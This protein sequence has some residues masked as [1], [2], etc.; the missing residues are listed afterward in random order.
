VFDAIGA[1]VEPSQF[2]GHFAISYDA[3]SRVSYQLNLANIIN[4]CFGG[5]QKPW[6]SGDHRWCNYG[7]IG[8]N[9]PSV[10]N[11]YNP[12][13]TLQ[14]LVKYPYVPSGTTGANAAVAPFNASFNVTFKL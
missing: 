2:S 12:G 9:L 8:G 1:F 7:V 4:T 6:V 3:T 5:T 11:F 13:D 14:P 10:G